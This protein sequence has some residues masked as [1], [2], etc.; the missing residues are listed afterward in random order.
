MTFKEKY[1]LLLLDPE[2]GMIKS[3]ERIAKEFWN[4]AIDQAF[5][6]AD[7]YHLDDHKFLR[8][9]LEEIKA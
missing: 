6:I 2:F 7:Q 1:Q 4:A 8:S 9:I 5:E 3:R